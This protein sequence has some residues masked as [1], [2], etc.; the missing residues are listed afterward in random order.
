MSSVHTNYGGIFISLNICIWVAK[1]DLFRP[2]ATSGNWG[3]EFLRDM[4][5]VQDNTGRIWIQEGLQVLLPKDLGIVFSALRFRDDFWVLHSLW[6]FSDVWIGEWL[7]S[8]WGWWPST[9]T[10]CLGWLLVWVL[11]LS[12]CTLIT[13]FVRKLQ[14]GG[15]KETELQDSPTPILVHVPAWGSV[16]F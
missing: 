13:L 16:W 3:I 14:W 5:I 2:L 9:T 4:S 11:S 12:F 1:G 7:G 6:E 8:D 15:A 10:D